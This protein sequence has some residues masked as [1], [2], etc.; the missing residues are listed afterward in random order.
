[1]EKEERKNQAWDKIRGAADKIEY[2]E[3]RII[4]QHGEPQRIEL[5]VKSVRLDEDDEDPADLIVI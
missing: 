3:L 5:I 1:M 2:G 4:I